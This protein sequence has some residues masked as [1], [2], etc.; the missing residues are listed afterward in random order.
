MTKRH[1]VNDLSWDQRTGKTLSQRELRSR[2][3][4]DRSGLTPREYLDQAVAAAIRGRRYDSNPATIRTF[5]NDIV[6]LME[7]SGMISRKQ[8]ERLTHKVTIRNVKKLLGDT[9]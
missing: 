8:G 2:M 1:S 5:H 3:Q 6:D 7:K 4:V 9:K